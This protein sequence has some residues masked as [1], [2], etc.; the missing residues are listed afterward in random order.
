[1][2]LRS[3]GLTN[4]KIEH[5]LG[6]AVLGVAFIL[7]VTKLLLRTLIIIPV[8]EVGVIEKP[9]KLLTSPLLPGVYWLNPWNNVVKISTRAQVQHESLELTSREG[10]NFT[11]D[12]GLQY[13]IDPQKSGYYYQ[14][15]GDN[16]QII[17]RQNLASAF[18]SV[19]S[20]YPLKVIYGNQNEA[21]SN[22]IQSLMNESLNA[23]GFVIDQVSLFHVILPSSVQ[24]SIQERFITE[25]QGEK[26]KAE[27]KALAEAVKNFQGLL[28]PQ[29]EINVVSDDS[30]LQIREKK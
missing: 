3:F 29:N 23:Q 12:I 8:G 4:V 11:A 2:T 26:R 9:E 21:I 28:T 30:T 7:M 20:K 6:S 16:S 22:K 17:L 13:H 27:A 15:I 5:K 1:M 14:N 10:I 24:S 19:T 18:T 25:Q